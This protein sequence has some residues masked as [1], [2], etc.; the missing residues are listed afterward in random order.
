MMDSW[1]WTTQ[2]FK[3]NASHSLPYSQKCPICSPLSPFPPLVELC[4]R[5]SSNL[6]SQSDKWQACQIHWQVYVCKDKPIPNHTQ[7]YIHSKILTAGL[8]FK[9][10]STPCLARIILLVLSSICFGTLATQSLKY[11]FLNSSISSMSLSYRLKI[12]NASAEP[13]ILMN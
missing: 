13:F 5:L 7:I 2:T 6:I 4:P 9:T 1:G 12:F 10:K 3:K 11:L 8:K